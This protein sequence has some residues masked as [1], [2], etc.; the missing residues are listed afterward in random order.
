MIYESGIVDFLS[1]AFPGCTIILFG[2]YSYGEDIFSSD[3][4]IAIVGSRKK[5]ITIEKY[6]K[7][8]QKDININ[9]YETIKDMDKTLEQSLINGIILKGYIDV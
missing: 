9:G 7:I 3:I 5:N 6:A 4:D 8:L 2:S 1:E